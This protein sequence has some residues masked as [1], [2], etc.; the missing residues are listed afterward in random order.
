MRVVTMIAQPLKKI[1]VQR[2][3]SSFNRNEKDE[4]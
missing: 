1:D 2:Q 4:H 3:S